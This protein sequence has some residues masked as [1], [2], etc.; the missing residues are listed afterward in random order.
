MTAAEPG[1]SAGRRVVPRVGV[2]AEAVDPSSPSTKTPSS[3]Q[4]LDAT[5]ALAPSA[6]AGI[7]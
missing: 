3:K 1:E 5:Y 6:S 2:T 4:W 7:G